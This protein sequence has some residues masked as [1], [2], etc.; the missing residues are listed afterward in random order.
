MAQFGINANPAITSQW[1]G[2]TILDDP[3]RQSNT[4]GTISFACSG[5]NTRV[6][7]LFINFGDN[8]YLDKEGFAPIGRVVRGMEHIDALYSG[9]GEG[10]RGD[11]KDGK[12]PGQGKI[13]DKGNTYLKEF[14]P[15]LSYIVS[16]Q[17]ITD[18]PLM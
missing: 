18:L 14:Y 1:R 2:R 6:S 13:N 15:Q 17:I 3:P 8:S 16:T 4:R 7:Q 5:K 10:G 9:Y 11:G 12:G